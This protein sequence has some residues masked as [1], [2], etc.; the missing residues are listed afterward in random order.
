VCVHVRSIYVCMCVCVYHCV[1]NITDCSDKERRGHKE[2][3]LKLQHTL[4][5]LQGEK[6]FS[7]QRERERER[8]RE[9]RLWIIKK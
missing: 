2:A 1:Y 7:R 3:V 4:L 8:E 6:D 9:R 5:L